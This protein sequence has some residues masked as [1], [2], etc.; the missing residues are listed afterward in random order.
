[1]PVPGIEALMQHSK[2][3]SSMVV[4]ESGFG[5]F[6]GHLDAGK[7]MKGSRYICVQTL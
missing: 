6:E 3:S 5:V 2:S 7:G 4:A 1:M